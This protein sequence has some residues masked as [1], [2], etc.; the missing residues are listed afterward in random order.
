[1]AQDTLYLPNGNFIDGEIVSMQNGLLKIDADY[2]D[3][4]FIIEWNEIKQIFSTTYFSINRSDGSLQDGYLRSASDSSIH[5]V[6]EDGEIH[7]CKP[8]DIIKLRVINKGFKNRFSAGLDVGMVLAKAD[9]MRKWTANVNVGYQAERWN[10]QVIA[11]ALSSVQDHSDAIKRFEASADYRF[12]FYK[13]WALDPSIS[14][15]SSTEQYLDLRS[16]LKLGIG[17]F[18]LRKSYGYWGVGAGVNRN[19]EQ[20][21][22]DTPDRNSWEGYIGTE[23]KLFDVKDLDFYT[24]ATAFPSFT[25]SQRWRFD[26]IF[27]VKYD[28]PH[29]FY[30]R[31]DC[32]VNYDNQPAEGAD[33]TDYV[34]QLGFGWSW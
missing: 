34:L 1:M 16:S 8:K 4:D 3:E 20:Y 6:A 24:S 13:D 29:D 11:S 5:I 9:N 23:V 32:T 18:L 33:E 12:L 30:V 25:E 19:M 7:S 27:N 2:G 21:T 28:L 14:F 31:F 22:N 17:K 15:L 10:S 26:F